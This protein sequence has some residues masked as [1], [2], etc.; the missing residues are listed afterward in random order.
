MYEVIRRDSGKKR[1]VEIIKVNGGK[2]ESS[3]K[4]K[5]GNWERLRCKVFGRS[6]LRI[7]IVYIPRKRLQST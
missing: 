6:I 4:V 1:K 3:S 7:F 2:V 5:E